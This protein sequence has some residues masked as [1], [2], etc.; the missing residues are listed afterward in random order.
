MTCCGGCLRCLSRIPYA[1]LIAT[2]LCCAGVGV[3]LGSMYR[4]VALSLRMFETVFK[5]HFYTLNDLQIIFIVVGASMAFLSLVLLLV[6]FLAT[7]ATREKIYRGWR[8]RLG[9]RISCA[10]FL[11]IT[12]ILELAWLIIFAILVVCTFVCLVWWGMCNNLRHVREPSRKCID[13]TQ[14]DFFFPNTTENLDL[15]IC[16]EGKLKEFCKDYVEEA[17]VMFIL[18]LASCGLVLLSLL[19][20]LMCLAANYAHIKDNE[21]FQDLQELQY[22]QE[23]EMGTLKDRF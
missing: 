1:T 19:H 13:L 4:G 16:S 21:K 14:F 23:T 20:Y 12:Y 18:S 15:K 7:G 9:G 6:G 2:V 5:I 22:L 10:C 8:A 17:S 11:T 3:F